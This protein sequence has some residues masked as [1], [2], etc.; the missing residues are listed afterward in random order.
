MILILE[1]MERDERE[2]G[3]KKEKKGREKRGVTL[4]ASMTVHALNYCP[5]QDVYTIHKVDYS[6]VLL[7]TVMCGIY[8]IN[9][10]YECHFYK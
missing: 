10:M 2:G 9:Q 8:I 4:H 6:F 7:C 3:R 5:K 1:A